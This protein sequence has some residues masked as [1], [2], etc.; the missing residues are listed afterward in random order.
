MKTMRR[1]RRWLYQVGAMLA[2]LCAGM[3][4]AAAATRLV[5]E[6]YAT[7][8]AA[9]DASRSGDKISVA[10]GTY[11][12]YLEIVNNNIAPTSPYTLSVVGRG[13][14]AHTVIKGT[15]LVHL[16]GTQP[17]AAVLQNL[18]FQAPP[19]Q[20]VGVNMVTDTLWLIDCII[21]GYA[22]GIYGQASSSILLVDTLV[23]DN[24]IGI[25]LVSGDNKLWAVTSV[26]AHNKRLGIWAS[27]FGID[28]PQASLQDSLVTWNGLDSAD[29]PRCGVSFEGGRS[30]SSKLKLRNTVFQTNQTRHLCLT[31]GSL[32]DEG[33]NVFRDPSAH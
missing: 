14:P 9:I 29:S 21:Y 17:A 25:Q 22:V 20:S 33:G 26:I 1:N 18:T 3:M 32:V 24:N 23:H 7:I 19:G 2:G 11:V 6:Q 30:S 5:P 8:Q 15:L 27:N 13:R 10:P 31:P 4:P 16:I 12:E 28:E